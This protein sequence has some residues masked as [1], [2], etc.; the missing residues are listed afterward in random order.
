[1]SQLILRADF[2]ASSRPIYYNTG[3]HADTSSI[4]K[5]WVVRRNRNCLR[6]RSGN[7]AVCRVGVESGGSRAGRSWGFP[8]HRRGQRAKAL[9]SPWR[10]SRSSRSLGPGTTMSSNSAVPLSQI[11]TGEPCTVL[12]VDPISPSSDRLSEMG[13]VPGMTVMVRGIAPLGDPL[14][15]EVCGYRISLRRDDARQILVKRL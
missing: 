7:P 1:M 15:I 6:Q 10:R 8:L 13:F 5:Q 9:F 11:P 14:D 2:S 3:D 4:F 12:Q